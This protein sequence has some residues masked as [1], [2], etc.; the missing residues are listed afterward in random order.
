MNSLAWVLLEE[1]ESDQAAGLLERLVGSSRRVFGGTHPNTLAAVSNLASARLGQGRVAEAERLY[2]RNVP[3]LSEAL[4]E[5]HFL[6]LKAR[7]GLAKTLERKGARAEAV[8]AYRKA[9]ENGSDDAREALKRLG[10]KGPE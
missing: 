2:R 5:D 9:A 10:E 7:Y 3:A 8:A 6:T 1:E 4:G